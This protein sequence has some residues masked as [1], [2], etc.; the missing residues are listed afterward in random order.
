M[1]ATS[2][3]RRLL[4]TNPLVKFGIPVVTFVGGMYG[5]Y[6]WRFYERPTRDELAAYAE[7]RKR[8]ENELN[9]GRAPEHDVV[10]DRRMHSMYVQG[11]AP[12][13]RPS[14]RRKQL[15]DEQLRDAVKRLRADREAFLGDF[16]RNRE[17]ARARS[18]AMLGG[19]DGRK[20]EAPRT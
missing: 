1:A 6:K 11:E 2:T 12:D 13:L 14:V 15:E 5:M 17:E 4:Y 20:G 18:L 16:A 10:V 7:Y 8:R 19:D 3:F 9:L